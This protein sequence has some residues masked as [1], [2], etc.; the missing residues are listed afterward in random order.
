MALPVVG[1]LLVFSLMVGPPSLACALT[2]APLE[3]FCLSGAIAL[4]MVWVAI[5]LSYTTNY[6]IGFFIGTLAAISYALG[7]VL[8]RR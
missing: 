8:R 2:N 4:V 6:P 1:A 3:A 7:R 5:A